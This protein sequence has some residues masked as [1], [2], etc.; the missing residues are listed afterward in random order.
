MQGKVKLGAVLI[1]EDIP[2]SDDVGDGEF[3][4]RIAAALND[5]EDF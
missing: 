2:I 5:G 1:S 3:E 4:D